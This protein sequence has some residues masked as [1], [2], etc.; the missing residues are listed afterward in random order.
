[1]HLAMKHWLNFIVIP[2]VLLHCSPIFSQM[3]YKSEVFDTIDSITNVQYGQ[4]L[5]LKGEI[6][7]L[8]LDIY[9]PGNDSVIKKPL[10]LFIHG[11]GFQNNTR[12]GVFSDM[13][14]KSFAKRGYVT[15]TIDYRLGVEATKTDKDYAEALYRAQQ[16]GRAA[17]RFF[18]RYADK[19][20]I[21]TSQIFIIGSSAGSM[22]CLAI[23]YMNEN[24]VPA[25]IDKKRWGTLE[26][27]GGN[28]GFSS[29]VHGV[30]NN[31]GAIIDYKWIQPGDVPLYNISGTN[32]KVVPYDSSYSYH[33]FKYGGYILYQQCLALGIKT[34][35]KPFYETGHTLDN[36]KMKFNVAIDSIAGW[37]YTI[38]KTD[39]I[40]NKWK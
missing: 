26:G 30:I 8:I 14:C 32:D 36:D 39:L 6:E 38:L 34:G 31:W 9:M 7:K 40:I 19:Y 33:N 24:E 2:A 25:E 12:H 21:D 17:I 20:G 18:R 29:T 3:R 22:T 35:W 10:L 11:G 4:V 37:L 28:E 16:D 23:A 5:N 15:S 27:S 1:M 13:I